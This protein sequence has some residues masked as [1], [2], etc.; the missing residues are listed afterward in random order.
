MS[1]RI[2]IVCPTCGKHGEVDLT[3]TGSHDNDDCDVS[4]MLAPEGFRKVQFGWS[5]GKLHLFCT[6]CGTASE[7]NIQ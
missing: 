7:Y 1:R 3:S 6:S 5:S 4:T 2:M